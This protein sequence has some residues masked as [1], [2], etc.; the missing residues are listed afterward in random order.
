MVGDSAEQTPATLDPLPSGQWAEDRDETYPA[1]NEPD[2]PAITRALGGL[3]RPL[4]VHGGLLVV[5]LL[6][7]GY[8]FSGYKF[9]SGNVSTAAYV[10]GAS[11]LGLIGAWFAFRQQPKRTSRY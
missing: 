10:L 3:K 7:K 6:I 9:E 11:L 4:G 8:V 2:V 5:I 1:R